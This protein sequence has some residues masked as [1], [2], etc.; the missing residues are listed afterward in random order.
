VGVLR[1]WKGHVY[2][3][4]AVPAI[5]EE[6]PRATF[7]IA[8]DGPQY[9]NIRKMIAEL[10]LEGKVVLLGHREDIP[11][12]LASLDVVV[13]PSYANEGIPQS[14]L[15]A[16]AMERAVVASDAGAIREVVIDG[17]TGFL[18]EPKDPAGLAEKVIRLY[19][20]PSLRAAFGREGR[21]LVEKN[22]SIGHML[23][24]IEALY[25]ALSGKGQRWKK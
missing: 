8:G 11:E 18:T 19:E 13:Q 4:R 10:S 12:V 15:Q 21:M 24:R 3:I 14:V 9:D 7:Y 23:D 16:M 25:G 1:S 17:K 6:I 20:M 22:H 5:L 2:F